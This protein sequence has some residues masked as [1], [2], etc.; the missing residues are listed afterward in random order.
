MNRYHR[1]MILPEIGEEGQR[2]LA[3]ARVLIVGAGGLGSPVISYLAGAGV[4]TMSISDPDRISE[5]NLHR[6][7]IFAEDR[8]G[9][10]KAQAASEFAQR[11]NKDLTSIWSPQAVTP[12]NAP[13]LA[14][15]FDIVLDCADSYAASY[16]LS[17]ACLAA[18]TPLISASV[19]GLTGYCGGFCAGAPS[20]RAVFPDL[21]ESAQ[22]CA[23]AGVLG[24]V[25]GIIGSIQAQMAL[26]VLLEMD[27]SPLG[28]FCHFDT[29]TM[30][31]TTFRFDGAPEPGEGFSFIADRHITADDFVI[32]LRGEDETATPARPDAA[33]ATVET[34]AQLP[35][36]TQRTVICCASGLRAWRAAERLKPHWHGEIVLVAL[37]PT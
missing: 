32:D 37:G 34:V 13:N 19:L 28:Q 10:Y 18:N 17:D 25:V 30:R 35:N 4:G 36:T 21:P 1:Q 20:L 14:E 15:H 9:L 2:K 26:A 24:P 12:D 33:R 3:D 22:T 11:R 8:I 29:T 16:T 31:S 27:P 23:T 7:V 6:Q 5:S